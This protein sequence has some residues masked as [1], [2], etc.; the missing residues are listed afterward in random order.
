MINLVTILL[1]PTLK[2][3]GM[4]SHYKRVKI[5]SILKKSENVLLLEKE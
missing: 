2:V 3:L 5:Q 4:K 1:V